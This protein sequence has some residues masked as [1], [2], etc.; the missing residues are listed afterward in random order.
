MTLNT[1]VAVVNVTELYP[2]V[3]Y[4]FT[5][6]AFNEVGNSSSSAIT[7]SRTLDESKSQYLHLN[8][9]PATTCLS[10]V[11]SS[12]PQNMN[13]SVN[14]STVILVT[15][16]EV[17]ALDQN[18]III[19]YEVLYDPQESFDG[20]LT[21][22]TVNTTDLFTYLTDLQQNVD[23]FISVRA[24]TSIGPGPYSEEISAVTLEDSK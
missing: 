20:E 9:P 3:T 10:L 11:P 19:I 4:N 13:V 12:F 7:P 15:W 5:V 2:G 24:Y 14:S 16:E 23:Y 18:G 8:I 17:P 6:I 22:Q 21:P 1:I